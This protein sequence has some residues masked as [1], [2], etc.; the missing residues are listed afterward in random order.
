LKKGGSRIDY[1]QKNTG[2][3]DTRKIAQNNVYT[4]S[5]LV[6]NPFAK[7]IDNKNMYQPAQQL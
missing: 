5:R 4:N 1:E 7:K 6:E 3:T 2:Q